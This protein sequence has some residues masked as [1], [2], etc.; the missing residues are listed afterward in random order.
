MIRDVVV[1]FY[2]RK[3]RP[4]CCRIVHFLRFFGEISFFSYNFEMRR[5][6]NASAVCFFA[7]L[8][9]GNAMSSAVLPDCA[10][11][12]ISQG[13]RSVNIDIAV[14]K[15]PEL[16]GCDVVGSC[17]FYDFLGKPTG[18]SRSTIFSE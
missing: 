16:F 2:P 13:N 8:D 10:L 4:R 15:F 18:E 1:E 14:S 3:F 12:T 11:F 6:R 7:Q 5:S 17:T 9:P